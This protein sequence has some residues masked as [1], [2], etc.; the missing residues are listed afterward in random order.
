M[1]LP[2]PFGRWQ[3]GELQLFEG[4]AWCGEEAAGQPWQLKVRENG[5][6]WLQTPKG[7]LQ[8]EGRIRLTVAETISGCLRLSGGGYQL[9]G[10]FRVPRCT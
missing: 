1:L 9:R 10:H 8:L 7:P 2:M 6:F 3:A 4:P 5:E